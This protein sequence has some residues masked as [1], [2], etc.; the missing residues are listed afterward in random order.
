[1]KRKIVIAM[2][3]ISAIA[4]VSGCG[5]KNTVTEETVQSTEDS[6]SDTTDE[7]TDDSEESTPIVA[8]ATKV[9]LGDYK[10]IT[11]TPATRTEVTDDDVETE[12][13]YHL[14]DSVET[15]QVTDRDVE[16]GDTIS[17]SYTQTLDGK[18]TESSSTIVVGDN[19]I[20][21]E[22]DKNIVGA[23]PGKEISFSYTVPDD[24]TD[25]DSVGKE[26]SYKVTVD[27]IS[28]QG[29]TPELTD[30]WVKENTDYTTV[31]DYKAAI[32]ENLEKTNAY[33]SDYEDI[34]NLIDSLVECSEAEI[35]E[36]ELNSLVDSAMDK[37]SED[38]E[39]ADMTVDEYASE[40]YGQESEDDL[41]DYFTSSYE[42]TS[43]RAAIV[44][45]FLEEENIEVTDE[46]KEEY[47]Q[48][49]ADIYGYD[50]VDDLLSNMESYG[51]TDETILLSYKENLAG[52]ALMD[53]ATA[54]E[55]DDDSTE[56]V[57]TTENTEDTTDTETTE[58][59]ED[60]SDDSDDVDTL[61]YSVCQ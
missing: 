34:S 47:L 7:T 54:V 58:R 38:A 61:Q 46:G 23:T 55:S 49:Q 16:S 17:I 56:D 20:D 22:F 8:S 41:R 42:E 37:V 57:E 30:D 32:K 18:E 28:E 14:E 44:D 19:Y 4:V 50:S 6:G 25:S 15:E 13:S 27:Y 3:C 26:V 36:D 31:D 29:E 52:R 9:T 53:I 24:A 39:S 21:S 33:N 45:K 35:S 48:N 12:I 60:S 11:Y 2:L 40:Y 43:T 1:M 5:S 10:S 59:T 51:I